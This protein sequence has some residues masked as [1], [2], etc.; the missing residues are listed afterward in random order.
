MSRNS[1]RFWKGMALI[2]AGEFGGSR[3]M[4][5]HWSRSMASW[6]FFMAPK[7]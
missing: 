2:Q 5:G 6:I 3:A 4:V 7:S 1:F